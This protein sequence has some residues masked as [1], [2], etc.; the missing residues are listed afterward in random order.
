MPCCAQLRRLLLAAV[1]LFDVVHTASHGLCSS[2]VRRVP[3]CLAWLVLVYR[4]TCSLLPGVACA[5]RP[6]VCVHSVSVRT[7][8]VPSAYTSLQKCK[9]HL[10][11]N[12]ISKRSL[13]LR[14][15]WYALACF[16]VGS[17]HVRSC[18]GCCLLFY[19]ST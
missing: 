15:E 3:C 5:L 4:S 11:V 14:T 2:T 19:C 13:H 10:D 18:T 12:T 6:D 1:L 17:C 7:A 9:D 16:S 8:A